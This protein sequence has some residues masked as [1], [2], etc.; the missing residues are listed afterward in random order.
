MSSISKTYPITSP[1][2]SLS[3]FILNPPTV[4]RIDRLTVPLAITTQQRILAATPPRE[5]ETRPHHR[6]AHRPVRLSA[7]CRRV[8]CVLVAQPAWVGVLEGSES[9][10]EAGRLVDVDVELNG[11][12]KLGERLRLRLSCMHDDVGLGAMATWHGMA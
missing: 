10:Q 8:G 6:L 1:P 12:L 4:V 5:A 11:Q 2:S 9:G 3:L 7:H